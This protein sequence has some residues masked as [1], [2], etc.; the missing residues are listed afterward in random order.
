MARKSEGKASYTPLGQILSANGWE[1]ITH[2]TAVGP[3][4]TGTYSLPNHPRHRVFASETGR[5]EWT[6]NAGSDEIAHGKGPAS[7]LHHLERF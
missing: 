6:H 3:Q 4:P 2:Q 7:L 1:A 5:Q